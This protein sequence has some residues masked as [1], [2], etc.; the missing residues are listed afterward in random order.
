M[1]DG[2]RESVAVLLRI[3]TPIEAA[4]IPAG[5]ILP[6]VLEHLLTETQATAE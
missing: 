6:Y 4:Y 5:E 3:V 1:R 2:R